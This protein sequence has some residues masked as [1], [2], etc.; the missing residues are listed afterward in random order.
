M[1]KAV[2]EQKREINHRAPSP[3]GPDPEPD[4]GASAA[5]VEDAQSAARPGDSR[6]GPSCRSGESFLAHPAHALWAAGGI[7]ALVVLIAILVPAGPLG[8]DRSWSEAMHHLETPQLTDLALVFNWLGRGVGRAL[9]L[10]LVGLLLLR[11]RRWLALAALAVAESLAPLLSTLLKVLVDRARPPDGLVHPVGAS[12]PS[13][14]TTYA[15]ATCVALVLLF[16]TL[17]TRRRWWW[18]LAGLGVVG[19]AWS[20]TYLQVHWLTDVVTGALL[21]SGISLLVFTIAQLRESGLITNAHPDRTQHN[22]RRSARN[23]MQL[24]ARKPALGFA[25]LDTLCSNLGP[26]RRERPLTRQQL[27]A[28]EAATPDR[29]D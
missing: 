10:T 16:T 2:P 29:L 8:L 25:G 28:R 7:L 22:A 24:V 18:A 13:G 23:A 1:T 6:S 14:H 27:L 17:G 20:R 12:F 4:L 11:R 21:G 19:M 26:H 9:A 5:Q 15:G 3:G